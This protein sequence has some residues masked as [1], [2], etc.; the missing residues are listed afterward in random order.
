MVKVYF[1]SVNKSYAQLVAV[2]SD[3]QTY[4]NCSLALERMAKESNMIVTE[5]VEDEPI[6]SLLETE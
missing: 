1:E 3:E 4:N 6:D 2:F 5:S